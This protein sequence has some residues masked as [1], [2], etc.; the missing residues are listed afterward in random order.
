[1]YT[2]RNTLVGHLSGKGL[3]AMLAA[4]ASAMLVGCGGG[5]DGPAIQAR[6]QTISFADTNAMTVVTA[7]GMAIGSSQVAATASS[8]LALIYSSVTPDVCAV[9]RHTGEVTV[10]SQVSANTVNGCRIA[11]DQY[12]NDVFAPARQETR[13]AI[14]LDP[15]QTVVFAAAPALSLFST[16]TVS[17]TA[18]SGLAVSYSSATPAICTVDAAT[19]LVTDLTAG[20]CTITAHQAGD[21]HFNAAP[22]VSQTMAVQV[23]TG[24]TAPGQPTG[25]T[26][27]LGNAPNTVRVSIA[28]T[29]S[30]GS[31]ITGYVV[32][33]VPAGLSSTG[34]ASPITVNCGGSCNGYAFSVAATN[35][36]GTS[37]PSVPADVITSY[38]VVETFYE[39]A[40]QPN[41]SI[42]TGTFDFNATTATVSNLAGTLTQ[43]MTGGS[44]SL[45]GG[46]SSTGGH[47]GDVPM[48]LVR[49]RHQLSAQPV[50]LGGVRG[51]L[52]T[53]FALP[54]TNTF[55]RGGIGDI[56]LNDGWSPDVGVDVG[57]VYYGFP[58]APNPSVGGVGNAYAMV[59]IN[60]DDPTTPLNQA[61][62][63]RLAY[64]D[65]T[66][67]GMMGAVCMTGSAVAGYTGTGSGGSVGTM[68]GYPSPGPT[69]GKPRPEA[70]VI[71]RAPD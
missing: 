37:A 32:T 60:T 50:T 69:P 66:A 38:T 42:F 35:A 57:G 26:A 30:G 55:F 52:V 34:T 41:N 59:F 6:A 25:V 28:A 17:A 56:P 16:A 21:T 31:A 68:G 8:G 18:S 53:T 14:R 7:G 63:D 13:I 4:M 27:T 33:S 15:T 58:T 22:E 44:S 10:N 64:A 48:T 12:G 46:A 67:G 24:I 54:T 3:T 29:D 49:L 9:D 71:T 23:P 1:M 70:Q 20:N 45:T 61:Q 39:P 51:L 11:A 5:G 2:H 40:T 62:K 43:S 47:Y 19:G 65:C 36:V